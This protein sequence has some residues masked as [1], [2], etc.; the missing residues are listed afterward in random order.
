MSRK[1]V[2]IG[3]SWGVGSFRF[4]GNPPR[5][6]EPVPDTGIDHYLK[7]Q[8]FDIVNLSEAG[9]S[10]IK[11][12]EKLTDHLVDNTA[13]TIIWFYTEVTRDLLARNFS[14]TTY[15]DLIQAAHVFNFDQAQSLYNKYQIPFIIIGGLSSVNITAQHYTFY[16][17]TIKSWLLD[18]V[19][20]NIKLPECLHSDYLIK[21][22]SQYKVKDIDFVNS[23]IDQ[24]LATEKLLENN[25]L[26]SDGIHPTADSYRELAN[27]LNCFL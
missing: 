18:I 26:F 16:K 14:F 10:N 20:Q 11:Q 19:D 9:S 5:A 24:M 21:V 2:I 7:H 17:H 1:V 25:K 6:L 23:Q 3:D 22:V 13:D 15:K 27:K 12:L 4:V 8:D